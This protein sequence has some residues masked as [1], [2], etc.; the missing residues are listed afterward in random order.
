MDEKILPTIVVA[1]TSI[2]ALGAIILEDIR[3]R[4]LLCKE[5][6][7][8]REYERLIYMDSILLLI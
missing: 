7:V 3:S 6:H 2:L 1:V 5:P 4:R 8:N